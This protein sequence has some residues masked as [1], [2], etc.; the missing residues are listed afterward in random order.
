MNSNLTKKDF[1]PKCQNESCG[2]YLKNPEETDQ[3]L[4][5]SCPCEVEFYHSIV[6]SLTKSVRLFF[7]FKYGKYDVKRKEHIIFPVIF[8]LTIS[9]EIADTTMKHSEMHILEF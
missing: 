5:V 4:S 2:K 8:L 7:C 6:E 3:D 9:V 1:K